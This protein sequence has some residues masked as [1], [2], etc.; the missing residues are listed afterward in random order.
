MGDG[1]QGLLR[2]SF[3]EEVGAKMSKTTLTPDEIAEKA[4][5]IFRHHCW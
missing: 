5:V 3:Q 4:R 2:S 1:H